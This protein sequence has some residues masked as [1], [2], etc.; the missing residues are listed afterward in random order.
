LPDAVA[1]DGSEVYFRALDATRASLVEIVLRPGGT[2]RPVRH[3]SVEEVWYF[4][5][6]SG[7]VWL[8]SPDQAT[9]EAR[10][11]APG[12]AVVIPT[13]WDFQFR[14]NAGGEL[15]FLCFT[16]PP[17]PGEDEAVAVPDGGLGEP[18]V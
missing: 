2:S 7:D 5:A 14:A 15:R 13:G 12:D 3:R 16:V 8:R 17:W 4:L 18:T 9:E 10:S 1:P 11:V 6:G